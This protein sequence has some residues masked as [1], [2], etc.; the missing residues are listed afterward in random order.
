MTQAPPFPTPS[1]VLGHAAIIAQYEREAW[2][3]FGTWGCAINCMDTD[4]YQRLHQK[5]VS[6]Q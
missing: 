4:R 3:R 2:E 5:V 6:L 1:D